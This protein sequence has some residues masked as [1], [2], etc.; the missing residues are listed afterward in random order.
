M[1]YLLREASPR[2]VACIILYSGRTHC[3]LD[4]LTRALS[5][6]VALCLYTFVYRTKHYQPISPPPPPPPLQSIESIILSAILISL[7][8]KTIHSRSLTLREEPQVRP[9]GYTHI[10]SLPSP[11][12][13]STH[14][15][16]NLYKMKSTKVQTLGANI[17]ELLRV[18]EAL[19]K[20]TR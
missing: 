19:R 12:P 3:R 15:L 2:H 4:K 17:G 8:A 14:P 11:L 16:G 10:L 7:T 1:V 6:R 9:L 5:T 13:I 18:R 20:R